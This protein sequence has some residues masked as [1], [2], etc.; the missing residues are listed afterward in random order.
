MGMMRLFVMVSAAAFAAAIGFVLTQSTLPVPAPP[1]PLVTLDPPDRED[2]PPPRQPKPPLAMRLAAAGFA[3]GD[4]VFLRIFKEERVMEIWLRRGAQFELFET[5]PV[6][7]F[8]GG[9][10][11]KQREGDQQSPEGFYAVGRAQLNPN[12]AYHLAFN[13]GF[14][15]AYDRWLKRTGSHL[16]VHGNCASIGCYAMTDIGIDD[17]YTLVA[18]ALEAGQPSV[19]VHIF[20]FRLTDAALAAHAGSPWDGFWANLQEGY[21]AFEATRV[22][23]AV[24][25]CSGRYVFGADGISDACTRISSW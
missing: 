6:C 25:A 4:P 9:L 23:P 14:P 1:A 19:S 16:M 17:I 2:L 3:A 11:P 15:N 24:F 22:P 13:L 18:A 21:A 8:S 10:G 20:P 12:S 7:S 5:V